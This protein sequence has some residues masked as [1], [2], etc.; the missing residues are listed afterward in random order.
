[1]KLPKTTVYGYIKDVALTNEQKDKIKQKRRLQLKGRP[2]PR[3]GKCVAGRNVH[4][5]ASW[6]N[7]LVHIVAHFMF[8]GRIAKE[9]CLYYSKNESQLA[10]LK[11]LV[12]KV[13]KIK[14][15]YQIRDNGVKALS[16]Y[17]V[18][19]A[20]YIRNKKEEIFDYLKNGAPKEQ[21]RTFLQA[22]FDDEGS[23]HF[24]KDK[25]RVR[26]YQKSLL[27]LQE[28][29]NIL[30]NFRVQSTINKYGNEIEITGKENLI[31]FADEINFSPKIYIN[32][33]RKNGIWKKRIE[34]RKILELA[35]KSYI[36]Q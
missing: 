31:R 30:E 7:E 1:V 32:P 29:N 6:S 26:G 15:R 22:F 3:K 23:I 5:P 11:D 27:I 4:K 25:R 17:Y 35:I 24:K 33:Y 12:D 2:S 13:F 18:D 16:Y 20:D 14:P 21:K 8:D 19:L 36:N 28:I 10:H 9:G 34:K